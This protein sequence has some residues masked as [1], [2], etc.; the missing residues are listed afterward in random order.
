M[1]FSSCTSEGRHWISLGVGLTIIAV[2]SV[3]WREALLA[4]A[5]LN[6]GN[7]SYNLTLTPGKGWEV[8]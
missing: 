1:H 7:L 6:V 4:F 5:W 8:F 2:N 3:H